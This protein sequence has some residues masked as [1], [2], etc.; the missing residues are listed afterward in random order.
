MD[1]A[2]VQELISQAQKGDRAAF[3]ILMEMHQPTAW[4]VAYRLSANGD[5][6]ENIVQDAF[7]QAWRSL[8]QFEGRSSFMTWLYPILVRKAADR[9]RE[10]RRSHGAFSLDEH[11][12]VDKDARRPASATPAE[13]LQR[14]ELSELILKAMTQLPDDQRMALVL[15]AQEGLS[16]RDAAE[17][18]DCSAGTVAWRVWNARRLLREMLKEH[19]A[20]PDRRAEP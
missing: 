7:V 19:I 6:A 9:H 13:E 3:G 4:R 15:T 1:Q 5:A 11:A 8:P 16:Y 20:L 12:A 10:L 14:Q 2:R 18:L 17:A